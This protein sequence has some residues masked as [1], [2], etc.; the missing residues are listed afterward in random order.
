M[1][2]VK[3]ISQALDRASICLSEVTSNP[4][5]ESELLLAD[6]LQCTRVYLLAHPENPLSKDQIQKYMVKIAR[7]VKNEPLPYITGKSEFYGV[8]FGVTS[9]VLIPRPETEQLV[10][11]A[12]AWLATHPDAMVVDV[13]TG[14]GCIAVALARNVKCQII[15]ATDISL[16]ALRVAR[17]NAA[18]NLVF[19]KIEFVNCD[20]LR[21]IRYPVDVIVSNPPYIA[22]YEYA[23]LPASIHHE[24]YTALIAGQ[25][26]FHVIRRLLFQ[27]KER[28]H[29]NGLLLVEI[30]AGQGKAVLTIA[31][32]AFPNANIKILSDLAG[33]DRI[34]CVQCG[35]S[36]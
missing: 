26:G 33:L 5:L 10:E 9:S 36:G 15:Y 25:D 7:R 34:L 29:S 32:T 3:I 11:V 19:D 30:G 17:E 31:K 24:P 14:S 18:K 8:Q 16:P 2:C 4:R 21:P 6:V 22:D 35:V 12:S 13:G 23:D 1:S 27:A 20:L 28:L